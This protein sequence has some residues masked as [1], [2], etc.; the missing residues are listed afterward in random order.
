MLRIAKAPR[1]ENL[2]EALVD[3]PLILITWISNLIREELQRKLISNLIREELHMKIKK[4]NFVASKSRRK[5][6]I[7][8]SENINARLKTPRLCLFLR[9]EH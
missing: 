9:S 1:R 7:L 2:K 3:L 4:L 8:F 5:S 6:I